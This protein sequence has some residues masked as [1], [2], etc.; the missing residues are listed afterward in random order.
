MPQD[1]APPLVVRAGDGE[2]IEAAGVRHLFA[3][4]ADRTHGRLG[5]EE[6][7]LPP[8]VEGARPHVHADHDEVFVVLAG[9]LTLTTGGEPVV[10]GPGDTAAALRGTVHGYRND[11]AQPA[12]ALCIYTP[13]GY[14][15]Y[16]RDVHD[17]VAAGRDPTPELLAGLRARHGTTSA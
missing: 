14:E 15:Q 5:L 8:G 9:E 12:R 7:A 4:T 1:P 16:F 10:L 17:A 6:F 2:V 3:L 13:A 11:S